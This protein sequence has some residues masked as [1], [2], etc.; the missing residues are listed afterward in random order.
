MDCFFIKQRPKAITD[1]DHFESIRW[2]DQEQI[3]TKLGNL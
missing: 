1:I 3:K 2:E